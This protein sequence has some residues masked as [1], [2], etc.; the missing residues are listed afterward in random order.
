M[1]ASRGL[2]FPVQTFVQDTPAPLRA[3][4][5]DPAAAERLLL[6]SQYLRELSTLGVAP[7]TIHE[8]RGDVFLNVSIEGERFQ[9]FAKSDPHI[10]KK[11]NG[12]WCQLGVASI[13][14]SC[15]LN[16]TY[17]RWMVCKYGPSEGRVD[18]SKLSD[19]GRHSF[20]LMLGVPIGPLGRLESVYTFYASPAFVGLVE[21]AKRRPRKFK[22]ERRVSSYL[23]DWKAVVTHCLEA[24]ALQKG[25]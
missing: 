24:D 2:I 1:D 11:D 17:E 9:A 25:P 8:P 21:W 20:A 14:R 7:A 18:L 12:G 23:G 16:G 22:A 5:M 15:G 13:A 19:A 4:G 10:A 3:P 6:A